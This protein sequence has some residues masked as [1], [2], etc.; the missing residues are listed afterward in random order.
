ME[1]Y[2][3]EQSSYHSI[4]LINPSNTLP[5]DSIRRL[6]EPLGLLYLGAVLKQNHFDVSILDSTCEGYYNTTI[7]GN[8]ITYGLSDNEIIERV[9]GFGPDLV[10]ISSMF[11]A[12][13]DNA[14]HHCELVK[15][16]DPNIVVVLGGIHPSL[17]PRECLAHGSVDY[18]IMGE[19]EFRL[20]KL[21]NMLNEKRYDFDFDGIAYWKNGE[22]V[23]HPM[24]QR[25]QDMDSIPFPARDLIDLGKYIEIGV[26]YAPFPRKERVGQV[27]TSRGCPFNCIF[28]STVKFWGRKFRMRS[29]DNILSEIDE[30]VNRYGIEEIQFADD[31]M[32]INRERAIDLSKRLKEY[33][34]LWCTPHGLM[35]KTLDQEMIRLMAESGAY[36]LT[37]AIESGSERV[38]KE[39]IR[40]PVPEKAVIKRLV[41]TCHE[42]DIQVHALFV[43]GFPGETRDEIMETLQYPFDIGFESVSFF[44]ANPLPGSD[45]FAKCQKKGYLKKDGWMM[46]FKSAEIIIPEDSP[47]FVMSRAEL[48]ELVDR[49]TREYNEFSRSKNLQKW[50]IKFKQFLKRHGDKSD[51][52]LGRVT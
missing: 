6:A 11:S 47:D 41:D 13:Q 49:K 35:V 7:K 16:V 46:D 3:K 18:V 17:A 45:L 28:C 26:P 8:Y 27:L 36:Q 52:I 37:F 31:N 38:L 29:V 9:K 12:H 32:T 2:K 40:K 15:S 30:L 44:L 1:K 51:L 50:E 24:E 10:G 48:V 39:I 21:L 20:L 43:L 23:V 42:C 14:L 33:N 5:K 22:I 19:G 4:M 34:L 25:I